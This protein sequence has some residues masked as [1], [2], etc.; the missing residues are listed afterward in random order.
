MAAARVQTFKSND[1]MKKSVMIWWKRSATD[2]ID[3][4]IIIDIEI[5]I[6][7]FQF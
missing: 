4:D 6:A 3:I 7:S 2:I 5:Q 1:F